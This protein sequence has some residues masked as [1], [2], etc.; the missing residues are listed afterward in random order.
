MS[1]LDV[2][3]V[4]LFVVKQHGTS[5]SASAGLSVLEEKAYTE[6]GNLWK[7]HLRAPSVV[8][9]ADDLAEWNCGTLL[10]VESIVAL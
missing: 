10:P 5:A 2:M 9:I 8:W 7:G 1:V 4:L 3:G 6:N